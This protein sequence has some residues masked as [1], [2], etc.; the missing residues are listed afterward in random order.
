MIM[1]QEVE[2]GKA[3][4]AMDVSAYF[5]PATGLT[6]TASS[7]PATTATVAVVGSSLK[8]TG[9]KIG[10]ATV[11]VTATD[12]KNLMANQNIVVT[13]TAMN[14]VLKPDAVTIPGVTKSENITI[15]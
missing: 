2:V 7:S 9:V 11:T 12:S 6:Y 13:V 3:T 1:D 5:T 10:T 14:A 15:G 8:I 4:A